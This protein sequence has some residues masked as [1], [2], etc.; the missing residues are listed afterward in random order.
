MPDNIAFGTI[1]IDVRTPGQYIEIDNSK[2]VRGLPSMNRRMLFIGNKLA[3]GTATAA[4]L[5]RINSAAEAATLFGRGSVL[6]EMLRVA[7]AANK[8][9]DMW[10]IGLD[11]LAGGLQGTQTL[12][13]TAVTAQAGTVA[14]YINGN[15]LSIGVAANDAVA[16]IATA[17]AANI[18]A[19]LDGPVTAAAVAGVV[20]LT[21]R[22]KGQFTADIDVRLNYYPDEKL[23]TGVTAVV[24]AG[25]A[26]TG[27]PDVATALAAITLESFYT[28]VTPYTDAA[29]VAKLEAEF[30]SRWG[31]MDMRAGHLFGAMRGTHAALTTYGAARNSSHSTFVGIK[32]APSPTYMYAAVLA[33]VCEFSGAIDPARPFQTLALPGLLP[34][35]LADRFTRQERDL[36]LRD[37][38]S[39]FLVDQGGNVL[40]ERVVT[41]YQVNAYGIDDVSYLDL[42]TKWTVDYMRYAFRA[43]IALRFPRHKL[44]DDG[45]NFAPGQ[46]V[47]TPNIIRAELLDVARDL[48]LAGILEGFETFKKDLLVTRSISD[49]NRVNCVLPADVVNQFRVF[50]AS[51][52]FIL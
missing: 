45:T 2:A 31:G 38:I 39:T 18:N 46:A 7:R 9:S 41:T 47:A 1:P 44:A 15:K 21:A 8:E 20:T 52:Q 4:S 40:V 32:S 3:G 24:A 19:W 10:A 11:D 25:V 13:F 17:T 14:L 48:E 26:G 30:A 35:A 5:V 42:E 43:R 6:Y 33:A 23:P 28:V 50:A 36:L 51:V 37:G 27:N 22:H 16:T 34:P 49:R 29:N 12:T